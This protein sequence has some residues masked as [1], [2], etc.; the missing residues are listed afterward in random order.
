MV[1]ERKN[2]RILFICFWKW[3]N[4]SLSSITASQYSISSSEK[5]MEIC[6]HSSINMRDATKWRVKKA[7][8]TGDIMV[9]SYC[10]QLFGVDVID[11]LI[12]HWG[13]LTFILRILKKWDNTKDSHHECHFS[14]SLVEVR[15]HNKWFIAIS[16]PSRYWIE[17]ESTGI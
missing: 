14:L 10:K 5:Q 6:F 7:N 15:R 2:S 12:Y 8:W 9:I 11:P 1:L 3:S 13:E 4:D 16:L 17:C